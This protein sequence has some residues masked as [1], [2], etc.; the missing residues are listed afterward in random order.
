MADEQ[1]GQ[2]V[3]LLQ[4]A[5]QLHHLPLHGAVQR[6]CRFIQ[7]DQRR[8][9]HQGPGNGNALALATG[10]LV[11]VAMPRARVQPDFLQ[12]RDDRRFLL[13]RRADLVDAQPFTDDVRHAHARAQAAERVLEHHL[14]F[15]P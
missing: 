1:V 13:L 5:Q 8:L 6:R 11:P 15:P 4:I 14:H 9:Q 3:L 7:Q 2:V 12:R 10:K